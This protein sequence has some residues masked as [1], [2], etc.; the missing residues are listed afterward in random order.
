MFVEGSARWCGGI[1]FENK[2]IWLPH[3]PEIHGMILEGR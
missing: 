1:V 2:H 3:M